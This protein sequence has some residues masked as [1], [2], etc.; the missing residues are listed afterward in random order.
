MHVLLTALNSGY[1]INSELYKKYSHET[2]HLYVKLYPW[3]YMP[4]SLHKM[5]IHG[6]IIIELL[7]IS[8][9]HASEEAIEATYKSLRKVREKHTL[10]T[11]R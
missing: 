3:Y 11:N 5:L 8:V 10:K 9:G 6:D 7:P 1:N 4:V 2:A